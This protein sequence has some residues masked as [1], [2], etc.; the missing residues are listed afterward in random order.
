MMVQDLVRHSFHSPSESEERTWIEPGTCPRLP[1]SPSAR[2]VAHIV[3]GLSVLHVR[4]CPIISP[5][6]VVIIGCSPK[7]HPVNQSPVEEPEHRH[8]AKRFIVRYRLAEIVYTGWTKV[9]K[10]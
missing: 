7:R 8:V 1:V 9:A 3:L 2:G 5:A 10:A 6:T 4:L